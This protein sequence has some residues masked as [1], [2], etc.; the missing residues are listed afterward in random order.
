MKNKIY[1]ITFLVFILAALS[2]FLVLDFQKKKSVSLLTKVPVK[3]S[4]DK[5]DLSQEAIKELPQLEKQAQE[6]PNDPNV[7][8]TLGRL[9]FLAGQTNQAEETFKT[10][11]KLEEKNPQLYV[12]LGLNYLSKNDPVKAEEFFK[13][14]IELNTVEVSIDSLSPVE[15]AKVL[16]AQAASY[17]LPTPYLH[18]ARLYILQNRTAEAITVLSEGIKIV[19]TYPD[20]FL[21]L[22]NIYSKTGDKQKALDF[23]MAF[24]KLI[25]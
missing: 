20:F 3:I 1:I 23:Q 9:Q 18:L 14:A 16:S 22:S 19:P 10:A 15:K 11:I 25:K 24:K 2:L 4:E 17:S 5:T 7:Q 8:R 12:D 21:M 6:K 13:K